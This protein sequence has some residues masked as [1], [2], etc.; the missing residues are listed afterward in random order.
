MI[1]YKKELPINT[2]LTVG[3]MWYQKGRE[4]YFG[5]KHLTESFPNI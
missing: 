1:D 2:K 3:R 4:A 5:L